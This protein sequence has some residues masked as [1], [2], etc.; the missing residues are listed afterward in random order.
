M[1]NVFF[2]ATKFDRLPTVQ[3][4]TCIEQN[5]VQFLFFVNNVT[6]KNIRLSNF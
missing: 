5:I 1:A 3:V 4:V 6:K 2:L